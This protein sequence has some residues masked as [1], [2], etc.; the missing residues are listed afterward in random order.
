LEVADCCSSQQSTAAV[1]KCQP[2]RFKK[3]LLK[4]CEATFINE[5]MK[6]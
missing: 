4:P 2:Q 5:G 1:G 6:K 3:T